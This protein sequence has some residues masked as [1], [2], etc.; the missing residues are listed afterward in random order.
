MKN[1]E[2]YK[3]LTKT[4]KKTVENFE[5]H[6]KAIKTSPKW[7]K[8]VKGIKN[9][10]KLSETMRK[11]LDFS[12]SQGN[13]KIMSSEAKCRVNGQS[14]NGM[15]SVYFIYSIFRPL[16]IFG[17]SS[18]TKNTVTELLV[19]RALRSGFNTDLRKNSHFQAHLEKAR[20]N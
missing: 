10:Q 6:S 4:I 1:F 7:V 19:F 13:T 8:T 15:L 16:L 11:G 2:C 9:S 18:C 3:N 17:T 5:E 12:T 14:R 20:E